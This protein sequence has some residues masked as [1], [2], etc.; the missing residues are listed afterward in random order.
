MGEAGVA[1]A[2]ASG[3]GLE[4][5]E[6]F[7]TQDQQRH[8]GLMGMWVFLLTELLLFSG[9]LLTALVLRWTHTQSVLDAGGRLKFWIGALNSVVLIVSSLTMALAIEFSKLGRQRDML[10]SIVATAGLGGLFLCFKAFEYFQDY[11]EHMMPF[12]SGRPYALAG[13]HASELFINLYYAATSLHAVHMLIGIS[14]LL[15]TAWQANHA[16]YLARRQNRIEI[17]GLYWHFIDLVWIMV[18]ATLY[19]VNR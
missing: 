8:A 3:V 11:Q 18:F 4:V 10:R 9:L 6:Q 15:F 13:D 14:L 16:G 19:L 2:L 17:V 12:L 7:S 1:E 5:A